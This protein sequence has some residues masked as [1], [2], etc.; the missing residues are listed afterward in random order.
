MVMHSSNKVGVV[1]WISFALSV[2]AFVISAV[3]AYMT[4][5]SGPDIQ[6]SVSSPQWVLEG[7]LRIKLTCVFSNRGARSGVI[8]DVML[9]L[10]SQDDATKWLLYPLVEV[11][12]RKFWESEEPGDR[13]K[14]ESSVYPVWVAGKQSQVVTYLFVPLPDHPDFPYRGI[15]PHKFKFV[16]MT[17]SNG[18]WEW[19]RQPPATIVLSKDTLDKMSPSGTMQ[20]YFEEFDRAR[21]EIK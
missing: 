17:R 8:D 7:Q 16:L 19:E 5:F 13:E 4:T 10:E 15:K 11:D 21:H 12:E 18:K 20:D 9:R 1:Q 3:I 14:A 6:V 2:L